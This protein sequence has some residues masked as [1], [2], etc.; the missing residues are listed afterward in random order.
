MHFNPLKSSLP[1]MSNVAHCT[2]THTRIAS[3]VAGWADVCRFHWRVRAARSRQRQYAEVPSGW[4]VTLPVDVG[5]V[6]H[7]DPERLCAPR[8]RYV[9]E[10]RLPEPALVNLIGM[11][12]KELLQLNRGPAGVGAHAGVNHQAGTLH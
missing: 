5:T 7:Q 10:R 3:R 4:R 1:P 2:F 11:R 9:V 8:A 6:V 12:G